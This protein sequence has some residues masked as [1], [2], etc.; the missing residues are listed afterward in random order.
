MKTTLLTLMLVCIMLPGYS[1]QIVPSAK[2]KKHT[3][4]MARFK[5][6]TE[7]ETEAKASKMLSGLDFG[8]IFI[9]NIAQADSIMVNSFETKNGSWEPFLKEIPFYQSTSTIIDEMEQWY[10]D[11]TTYFPEVKTKPT[12]DDYGRPTRIELLFFEDGAWIPV[13]A[14]DEQFNELGEVIFYAISFFDIEEEEWAML[15]GFRA[16]EEYNDNDALVLRIWEDFFMDEWELDYKEEFILN[17]QDVTVEIIE[18][19][20]DD[21]DDIW[22]KEYRMVLELCENNMWQQGYSY[23]WDWFEEEWVLELKYLEFEWFDFSRMLFTHLHVMANADAFDDWDDWKGNDEVEW[24][25]YMRLTAEY[26]ETGLPTFRLIEEWEDDDS[27]GA[28]HPDIKM[29]YAYDHLENIVYD[30]SSY[31]DG[32]GWVMMYGYQLD[33]EYHEDGSIKSFIYSAT[34]DE[35][36]N[37][38]NPLMHYI[39]YYSDDSTDA[40]VVEQPA[41][42]LKVY[43]NPA[44]HT[45]N[46]D[47]SENQGFTALAIIGAD[48][49]IVKTY[50]P[51]SFSRS[52][53]VSLNVSGLTN[54]IYFI[55]IQGPAEQQTTRFIKR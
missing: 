20:Y 28:W 25:N 21:Y 39:Y 22:E 26:L 37:D 9:R 17:E 30:M 27:E 2:E 46:I 45:I 23:V 11:G 44:T 29:E 49:R 43:P 41:F 55:R 52:Q 32:S 1:S 42:D 16:I 19:Y 7:R 4:R 18:Y 40:P 10:F 36:E 48:G 24:V 15:F 54:G 8:A 47:L 34:W 12:Y 51:A 31:H 3:T 38:L 33:M 35:R 5:P 6:S 53:Q 13:F 14:I 50:N